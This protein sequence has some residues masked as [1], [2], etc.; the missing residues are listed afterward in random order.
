MMNGTF[1]ATIPASAL[2]SWW[3][4]RS[5]RCERVA[6]ALLSLICLVTIFSTALTQTA[7]VL[8][9]V[10]VFSC[11]ASEPSW[12]SRR[13]P[14]D[15]PYLAFIA[16]RL[17]SVVFSSDPA[18]S[19]P[20]L[21][22]EFFFYLVFFMVTQSVRD[23]EFT[24]ARAL[25]LLLVLAGV[26]AGL[27]GAARVLLALEL[28]GSSTTAGPYTLGAY[29]CPVLALALFLP[30]PRPGRLP[31]LLRGAA[32]AAICLG[33]IFTLNRLH[34]A[35]ML[36]ALGGAF[37]LS[38]GRPRVLLLVA[39][40]VAVVLAV[41]I[42]MRLAQLADLDSF[43][44]GRDL[45][46]RGAAELAGKHP[47]V[48]FGPRTF[49]E[50]FPFFD[51]L[52]IRG[53]SSWHNDYLQ[54]YMESGLVGLLPLLWLVAATVSSGRRA[55]RAAADAPGTRS[56][57]VAL[58]AALGLIFL[59]GGMLDTLVGITFR[60]LLGLFALLASNPSPLQ[61]RTEETGDSPPV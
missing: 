43:L 56:L 61:T 28:R 31:A 50:V 42:R 41:G 18:L 37:F 1:L 55:L 57:L 32:L 6:G 33:I 48:G 60:I 30:W 36:L 8:L 13:T 35:G 46:W 9:F 16:G 45:L 19:M 47:I 11:A 22:H 7:V 23:D 2:L 12:R 14:L 20:A 40:A 59:L 17:V 27:I 54:V 4:T 52:P 5:T 26:V 21:Y 39:L 38:R 49:V 10:V 51:Q 58:L 29:L 53:V 24:A 25:T 3:K 15:V 34:W 44:I